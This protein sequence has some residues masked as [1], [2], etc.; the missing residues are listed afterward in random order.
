MAELKEIEIFLDGTYSSQEQK[1]FIFKSRCACN[2]LERRLSSLKFKS[3][4]SRLNIHCTKND[5]LVC[6]RPLKHEPFLEIY[7]HVDLPLLDELSSDALQREFIRVIAEGLKAANRETPIPVEYCLNVLR[8]FERNGFLNRWVHTEKSWI[9][10]KCHCLIG[11]E[12]TLDRCTIDQAIYI[13]DQLVATHRIAETKPRE[14]IFF[15]Y[16]GKLSLGSNG[17]LI[18]KKSDRVLSSF[19]INTG[20]FEESIL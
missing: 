1:S 7:I 20:K 17:V 10:Q 5:Q 8:E 14:G 13:S 18:Y 3:P 16:L 2:Y 19:N 12:I 15:D 11:V 9:R 6:V 4:F